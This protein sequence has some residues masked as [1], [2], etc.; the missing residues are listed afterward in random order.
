MLVVARNLSIASVQLLLAACSLTDAEQLVRLF[1]IIHPECL[2]AIT[3]ATRNIT[4][5]QELIL[6]RAL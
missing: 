6:V 3:A 5:S 1:H 2:S 4:D